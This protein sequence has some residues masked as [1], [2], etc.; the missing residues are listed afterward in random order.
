MKNYTAIV[1]QCPETGLYVGSVPG[2]QGAHSQGETLDEL[3]KNL[4]EVIGMLLEDGEP[5][6]ESEFIGVQKVAVA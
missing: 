1:E 2:F 6:M 4:E 5:R 3:R